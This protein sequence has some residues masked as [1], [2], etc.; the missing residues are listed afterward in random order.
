[1]KKLTTL[2]NHYV[3]TASAAL[4]MVGSLMSN[5]AT[6]LAADKEVYPEIC[7]I[8]PAEC[9]ADGNPI[10][11]M[12]K[13]AEG[14]Y[15]FFQENYCGENGR[16]GLVPSYKFREIDPED[17]KCVW[18][19][20]DRVEVNEGWS[21]L[22]A[23][24]S[25]I[26][27]IDAL[28]SYMQNG[29]NIYLSGQATQLL[30]PM[31]RIGAIEKANQWD[32][33]QAGAN[34][35]GRWGISTNY[36]DRRGKLHPIFNGLTSY[37]DDSKK[38]GILEGDFLYENHNALWN[39]SK[40]DYYCDNEG[41]EYFNQGLTNKELFEIDNQATVLASFDWDNNDNCEYAGLIEFH[42]IYCWSNETN[43]YDIPT[44][45]IIAN[46]MACMQWRY[47]TNSERTD[48]REKGANIHRENL[49]TLTNNILDYLS[50]GNHIV[51]DGH[52]YYYP[53]NITVEEVLDCTGLVAMYI[54]YDNEEALV[55]S[56]NQQEY[57]AYKYF[58]DYYVNNP[59]Y[60]TPEY[61]QKYGGRHPEILWK[62]DKNKIKFC[63]QENDTPGCVGFECIWVNIDGDR[64]ESIVTDEN[65]NPRPD[66]YRYSSKDVLQVFGSEEAYQLLINNL[67]QFRAEG[68][69]IYT[70]K[71]AN[72]ILN[73]IDSSIMTPTQVTKETKTES[74][75]WG[76][77]VNFNRDGR[78]YDQS[79]HPVYS[80][81]NLVQRDHGQ[82]LTLFSGEGERLDINCLWWLDDSHTGQTGWNSASA[83]ERLQRFN[84]EHNATVL[85]VWGHDADYAYYTAAMVE[86]HPNPSR[87]NRLTPAGIVDSRRGTILANG[88]GAYEW[89]TN[90]NAP[91]SD[92]AVRDLTDNVISYLTPV[93]SN[94]VYT[95][96]EIITDENE[97]GNTTEYFTLQGIPVKSPRNG[98]FIEVKGGT[99]RKINVN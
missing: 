9:G 50:D 76:I 81:L 45:A 46:G 15:E 8:Y 34:D 79:S 55:K 65:G 59:N 86:F 90:E 69:N 52:P 43:S 54:G 87:M 39:L 7:F 3:V 12:G 44:G 16:G 25:N 80:T 89:N 26:M 85:G 30:S 56:N 13:Q 2:R 99:S 21:N 63:G 38:F 32:Q 14:A 58:R 36:E 1:M 82:G 53:N 4:L 77:N 83:P 72:L 23:E 40:I 95:D 11:K 88:V 37:A 22:P 61:I 91:H 84:E 71:Y 47:F 20:I 5:P 94:P 48:E 19:H 28:K 6:T 92:K 17:T 27:F 42:P 33:N 68:G 78:T 49:E 51:K 97:V 57:S 98:I 67:Q 31:W 75:K 96:V 60:H 24:F 93:K 70:T 73:D 18:I 41:Q 74:D 35:P 29:G 62:G 64:A 66:G 10:S